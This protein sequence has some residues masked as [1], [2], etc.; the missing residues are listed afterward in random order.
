MLDDLHPLAARI[1]GRSI[2]LVLGGGGAR[3]FAHLGVLDE[4]EKAG[5]RVDRFAGTSMGAVIAGLGARGLNAEAADGYA[6]EYFVRHNPISDYAVPSKGLVR[7]R[8]T[9]TLLHEAFAG[10]LVEE[11]PKEFRCV[12]VDLLARE[13]VVHRRG[14][15]AD[16]IGCSLRLPGLYPP[17]VYNDRLHVDGGVL[18]NLPISTLACPEGP[19]IAVS[20]GL[21]SGGP[22]STRSDGPPKVPGIGDT[23]MRTMTIGSQRE[24]D[25]CLGLAEVVI[26]P[27]TRAVGLLEFH[28]IDAAREAGRAAAREA[29]PQ[30]TAL[31][32]R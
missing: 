3:G 15:V 1:A 5:I 2:G 8:R 13:A 29:L 26:R 14:V 16:V 4:L 23:L 11:L 6:Y 20:I 30:I 12:S 17:Y 31:V 28:Q 24:T 21:G 9:V 10:L 32:N 19:V 22:G 25:A 27:D 18:N 7:G